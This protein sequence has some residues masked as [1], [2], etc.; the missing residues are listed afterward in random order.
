MRQDKRD[1]ARRVMEHTRVK[2][3]RRQQ[4]EEER[5][6]G[7]IE[8]SEHQRNEAAKLLQR[9]PPGSGYRVLMR[10][11]ACVH[12]GQSPLSIILDAAYLATCPVV[13]GLASRA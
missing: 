5:D 10:E 4:K 3:K 7:C 12:H 6:E 11:R 8:Q 1:K 13:M 9:V 2:A